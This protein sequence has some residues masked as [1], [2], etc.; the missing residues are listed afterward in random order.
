MAM[1]EQN[2]SGLISL[3]GVDQQL[4]GAQLNAIDANYQMASQYIRPK[5][6]PLSPWKRVRL[7]AVMWFARRLSVPIDVHGSFF[8]FGKNVPRTSVWGTAPK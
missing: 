5:S 6:Q 7:R 8:N 3:G 4:S 2:L 1:P